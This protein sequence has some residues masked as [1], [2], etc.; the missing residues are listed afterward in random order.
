[1]TT[2][3]HRLLPLLL[4]LACG[5]EGRGPYTDADGIRRDV[6]GCWADPEQIWEVY[7]EGYCTSDCG[8]VVEGM[9][10]EFF[11][12]KLELREDVRDLWCVD[13]CA[14]DACQKVWNRFAETCSDEDGLAVH[15]QCEVGPEAVYWDANNPDRPWSQSCTGW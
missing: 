9:E 13:P 4:A 14:M 8:Q 2:D 11:E 3:Q 6:N 10:E 12:S 7:W 5:G 15:E 1:M